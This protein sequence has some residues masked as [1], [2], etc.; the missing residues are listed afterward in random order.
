MSESSQIWWYICSFIHLHVA[1]IYLD[2]LFPDFLHRLPNELLHTTI[3]LTPSVWCLLSISHSLST[4]IHISLIQLKSPVWRLI[5]SVHPHQTQEAPREMTRERL[6]STSTQSTNAFTEEMPRE[7]RHIAWHISSIKT[8]L[9]LVVSIKPG[10]E[11]T[12]LVMRPLFSSLS[13]HEAFSYER[14]R[15]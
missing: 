9:I 11:A 7:M 15:P 5:S 2:R 3:R 4:H 12:R 6:T 13:V 1:F 10:E 14:I 8:H